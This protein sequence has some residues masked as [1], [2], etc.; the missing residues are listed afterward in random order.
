MARGDVLAAVA[1]VRLENRH[2]I[3]ADLANWYV[4]RNRRRFW[5]G[6]GG[7]IGEGT[8]PTRMI[9]SRCADLSGSGTGTADSRASVY[10]CRGWSHNWSTGASSV[11][12]PRY[13]TATEL[14]TCRTTERSCAM[15]M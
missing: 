15:K 12:W 9:R 7:L 13:M 14:L 1:E 3:N 11:I 10:G 8:S 6:D 4:R 2:V 5:K